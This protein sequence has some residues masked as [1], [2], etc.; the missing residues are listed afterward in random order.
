MDVLVLS[1]KGNRG[2][3]TYAL[4][5]DGTLLEKYQLPAP[6]PMY[7]CEHGNKLYLAL[8]EPF[9][10]AQSGVIA[11]EYTGSAPGPLIGDPLDC[12]GRI[13]CHIAVSP[14]GKHLLTANYRTGSVSDFA[15]D[16][17]GNILSHL[18]NL[19]FPTLSEGKIPHS[20]GVFFTQDGTVSLPDLGNDCI[21]L[22]S[23]IE[24][25]DLRHV[26]FPDG[27]GPRHMAFSPD[28]KYAY[29]VC[30]NSSEVY[31]LAVGDGSWKIM[32]VV[33]LVSGEVKNQ[34][35]AIRISND[36][37]YIYVSNRGADTISCLKLADGIP[38]LIGDVPCS[39]NPRDFD[40]SPDGRWLVLGN[41]DDD[42]I[43]VYALDPENGLPELKHKIGFETPV[44]VMFPRGDSHEVGN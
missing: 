44:A 12:N 7:A 20:H 24:N 26:D 8:R 30:Q 38:A 21:F 36:G 6:A 2:V 39:R 35:S 29:L 5:G 17:D 25:H 27:S 3:V 32:S 15:L 23:K 10:E 40:L 14:D 13:A 41:M 31:T 34:S 1:M 22:L 37:R 28:G 19:D 42:T 43:A 33:K 4:K 18:G 9:G 11:A 16:A